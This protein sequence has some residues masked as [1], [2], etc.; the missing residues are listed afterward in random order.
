VCYRHANIHFTDD[1]ERNVKFKNKKR[2]EEKCQ[3]EQKEKTIVYQQVK[4]N[5]RYALF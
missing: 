1:G 3:E 4:E 5:V 2:E